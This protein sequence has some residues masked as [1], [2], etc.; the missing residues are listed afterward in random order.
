MKKFFTLLLCVIGMAFAANAEE[1]TEVRQCIN[2]L[3]V[4]D[5]NTR[6]TK[7]PVM[8]PNQDGIL[9]IADVTFLIDKALT[10]KAIKKAPAKEMDIE[11]LIHEVLVSDGDPNINDVTDAITEKLNQQNYNK[12]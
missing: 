5:N 12:K 8:D 1:L 11:G 7:A 9:S 6:Y 2:A 10:E 3:L 4:Q